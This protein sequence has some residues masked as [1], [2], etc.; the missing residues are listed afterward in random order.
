MSTKANSDEVNL[1]KYHSFVSWL[2]IVATLFCGAL[3]IALF[4]TQKS[5]IQTVLAALMLGFMFLSIWMVLSAIVERQQYSESG[6]VVKRLRGEPVTFNWS[7]VKS[8]KTSPSGYFDLYLHNGERVRVSHLFIGLQGF[9][10]QVLAS[11]PASTIDQVTTAQLV[12]TANGISPAH[13]S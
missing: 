10:S 11:V 13:L 1:M 6:M 5:M 3:S 2:G 4:V 12:K 9:A 8:V 7:E